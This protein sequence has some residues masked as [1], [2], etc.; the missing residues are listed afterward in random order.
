[1]RTAL[2]A[3][4]AIGL[5]I[6]I[7]IDTWEMHKP[8]PYDS[9][10]SGFPLRAIRLTLVPVVMLMWG[11]AIALVIYRTITL[12]DGRRENPFRRDGEP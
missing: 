2:A 6:A 10:P 12:D 8:I 11:A 3:Y 7:G 5:L 1:V 9:F 4:F